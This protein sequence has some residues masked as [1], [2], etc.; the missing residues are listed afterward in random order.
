MSKPTRWIAAPSALFCAAALTACGGGIPSGAVVKVD[1]Q[2][3]TKAAYKHWLGIVNASSAGALPGQKAP[4]P[5]VPE[6]PVYHSCIAHLKA[7]EPNPTKGQPKTTAQLK[8]Q[9]EQQYKMLQKAVLG[10]LISYQWIQSEAKSLGV[11]VSDDEVQK[12]FNQ[13]K[14]QQFPKQAE[15]QKY[16]AS[17]GQRT[18]DLLL[19]V[20]YDALSTKVGEKVRKNAL[21]DVSEAQ[22]A[23]YYN[24]HKT[25]YV[26]PETRD[27]L[28]VLTKTEAG[29][30]QAHSEISAGKSF[31]AV[32][33]SKSIDPASKDSGGHV[34]AVGKGQEPA[35]LDEAIFAAKKSVL[36]GP[37]KTPAGY[38][39]FEVQAIHASHQQTLAQAKR[40][41]RQ[42]LAAQGQQQAL[43]KFVVSFKKKWRSKTDC[44]AGYVVAECKQYK[45]PKSTAT[46]NGV[47]AVPYQ[48]TGTV[49]QPASTTQTK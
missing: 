38:Y 43:S 22:I 35:P 28:I 10:F 16:L 25:Q 3:I 21:S 47:G 4:K 26:G 31:A 29:A 7:T 24:G 42:L 17:T 39:V 30:E 33:K 45:A 32:A 48:R 34:A 44:R 36:S 18:A 13:L 9:C 11:S 23:K 12:Q 5:V 46:S 37:V 14:N 41:V 15:F 2:L 19:R 20:K 8:A 40:Q 27:L 1:G 49:A 6:P